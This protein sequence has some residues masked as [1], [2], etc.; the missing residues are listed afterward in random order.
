MLRWFLVAS[1]AALLIVSAHAQLATTT[2]LVGNVTDTSG[3]TVPAA[4]VT[5]INTGT[6]DT[7][8]TMT[9]DQ[10]FFNIQF[11]HTGTYN[12]IVEKSGFQKIEKTG[13][14]VENNQIV[15]TDFMLAV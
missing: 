9:N 12:V 3:Q 13:V 10:G 14:V 5:A 6:G 4:K 7:Y 8:N 15:R 2:A 11:V 1:F